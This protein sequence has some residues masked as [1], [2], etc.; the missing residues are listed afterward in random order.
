VFHCRGQTTL[1]AAIGYSVAGS[2]NFL[3]GST[4]RGGKSEQGAPMRHAAGGRELDLGPQLLRASAAVPG[5][6][7]RIAPDCNLGQPAKVMGPAFR[8]AGALLGIRQAGVGQAQ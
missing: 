5:I 1:A 2:P 6:R 4:Y 8:M 7:A 3:N